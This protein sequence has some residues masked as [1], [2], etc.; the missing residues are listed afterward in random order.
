MTDM[1]KREEKTDSPH[2]QLIPKV[3]NVAQKS[4]DN[5][6]IHRVRLLT[7]RRTPFTY[8]QAPIEFYLPRSVILLH[9]LYVKM[10]INGNIYDCIKIGNTLVLTDYKNNQLINCNSDGSDIDHIPLPDTPNNLAVVDSKTLAVSCRNDEIILIINIPTGSIT[11]TIKTSGNCYGVSSAYSNLYVVIVHCAIQIMDLTGKVIRTLPLPSENIED[12]IVDRNRLVCIDCNTIYC[13]TLDGKITWKSS[14]SYQDLR[15]VTT[16]RRGTV[17]VTNGMTDNVLVVSENG[18]RYE[19]F[20]T[21][22]DGMNRPSGIHFDKNEN[23][24]FVCNASDGKAFLFNV[25]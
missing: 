23:V 4:T 18:H 6:D 16:D 22:S 11:S 14:V 25:K 21:S 2:E 9:Q 15:R 24:L 5:E 19:E 7:Y 20:L 12:I 17:Y 8:A 13:C 1:D 10:S 3:V